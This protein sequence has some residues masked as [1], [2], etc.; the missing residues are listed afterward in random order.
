MPDSHTKEEDFRDYK[1]ASRA[2]D[3]IEKLSRQDDNWMV[4]VGFKL[5]HLALHVPHKYFQ[6]YTDKGDKFIES[7]A[8]SEDGLRF[9]LSSPEIAYRCCAEETFVFQKED[10]A[11]KSHDYAQIGNINDALPGNIVLIL[12]RESIT[13]NLFVHKFSEDAA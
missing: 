12:I 5:P 11:V 6:L 4:A 7:V 8:L 9:P 1:F 13:I 2:I 3:A 10:G